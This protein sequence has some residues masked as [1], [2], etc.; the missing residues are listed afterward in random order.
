MYTVPLQ[1]IIIKNSYLVLVTTSGV[2]M[3]TKFP[4]TVSCVAIS[5]PLELLVRGVTYKPTDYIFE[6]Q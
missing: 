5:N 3:G 6:Y 1:L 2:A 4:A